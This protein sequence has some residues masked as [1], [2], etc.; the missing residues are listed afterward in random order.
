[1]I[2]R[3]IQLENFGLY[4]GR[5]N[6]DLVPRR[7]RGVDR[8]IVLIGGKNGAGKTTLLEA[9]RLALYGRR[10]LGLRVA[11]SEYEQYLRDRVH[12]GPGVKGAA[13]GLEFDYAEGGHVHRFRVRRHWSVRN[14]SVVEDL[15][16][17]KNDKLIDTV[18]RDEWSNFLQE[19]IPPGVSQLFFFDGEKIREIADEDDK[20]EQ[21]ADAIRGLLGIELVGNLRADIGLYLAKQ[22]REGDFGLGERLQKAA[23]DISELEGRELALNDEVAELRAA[24]DSQAGAAE[25]IRRRFVSEG[26]D[27]AAHRGRVEGERTEVRRRIGELE[28]EFRVLAGGL[29][30]FAVAPKLVA[31]FRATLS[32]SAAGYDRNAVGAKLLQSVATW[33]KA[34]SPK[35]KRSARW[36]NDHWTDLK[37]LITAWSKESEGQAAH[38]AIRAL[39][40]KSGVLAQ[41]TE[42]QG[43]MSK[44]V[45]Q[46]RV[47]FED[48]IHR[49]AELDNTLARA[50]SAAAGLLLDELRLA[51]QK[52]GATEAALEAKQEELRLVRA[53]KEALKKEQKDIQH[54]QN[55]AAAKANRTALAARTAQVLEE[56]ESRLL[57]HKLAQLRGEFVSRFNHLA[58]KGEF[59]RDIRFHAETFASTLVDRQGR[60]IP[61]SALSA[62]EKQVYAI[63]MLW[64]LAR[65]SGRP[66]PMIIDT[67]LARLDSD[68]RL[69]LIERYFPSASHQVVLLSTDTE[70]DHALVEALEESVSHAYRLDFDSDAESTSVNEGYF[71]AAVRGG[72]RALHKA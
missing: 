65:T 21:L 66:L 27:A 14:K 33:K 42:A 41:L 72:R 36:T 11:Q 70:V 44:R 5:V 62:G 6:V 4:S 58:R 45:S 61:K 59:I 26:G 68:H 50:D 2:L 48:L 52:L 60:E 10:A 64:A 13:V 34:Q 31:A 25:H 7:R 16:L 35:P 43:E 49:S 24:R 53:K 8:P 15:I 32:A 22:H 20:N 28:Q 19:L 18:P 1:M 51:E 47:E 71:D 17:D 39:A 12:R 67:P 37:A 38:S 63:A 57:N 69:N 9:V 30:P 55:Q 23:A 29:L 46:L 3:G 54:E 56:F 40:D